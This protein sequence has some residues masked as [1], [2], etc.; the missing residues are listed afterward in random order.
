MPAAPGE[1]GELCIR[2]TALTLG[3][4]DDPERTAAAFTQNPLNPHYPERIYRTGDLAVE[5]E[6]GDLVFVSRKDNQIKN[7]GHRIELG[8]IESCACMFSGVESAC[9]IFV[10]ETSKLYLYYMGT[11]DE[12]SLQR[13][14]RSELP[15]HMLP[16]KLIKLE[17][18]PLLP[19]GKIDRNKLLEM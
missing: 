10:K 3:Y 4:F 6:S 19:N 15:R 7:M 12:K 5:T 13:Y 11:A 9:C 2:G 17:T 18:L 16:S 8:E 14:M 1:Q